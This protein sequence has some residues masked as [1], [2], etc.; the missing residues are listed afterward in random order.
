MNLSLWFVRLRLTTWK[1]SISKVRSSPRMAAQM[2]SHIN[3]VIGRP[4][5][6]KAGVTPLASL[7]S[8]NEFFQTVAVSD[9]HKAASTFSFEAETNK[10]NSFDFDQISTDVVLSHLSSL[11]VTKSTGP[12]RL[13]A[14]FLREVANVIA[15]PLTR[16]CNESLHSGIVPREWKQA[17]TQRG[18]N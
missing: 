4:S 7:D 6:G 8:I 10:A 14:F 9:H 1:F 15:E 3:T 13:S 16:L 18:I 5:Q 2:W 17:H 12:D 11:D